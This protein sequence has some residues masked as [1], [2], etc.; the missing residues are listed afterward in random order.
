MALG[1][2]RIGVSELLVATNISQ[3]ISIYDYTYRWSLFNI[4]SLKN[5]ISSLFQM[6]NR[7]QSV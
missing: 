5:Y 3:Y 4:F 6:Q 7:K 2:L 1:N